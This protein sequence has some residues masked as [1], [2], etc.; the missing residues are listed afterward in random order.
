MRLRR[1]LLYYNGIFGLVVLFAFGCVDSSWAQEQGYQYKYQGKRD[2]FMSLI[3]P[4]GFLVNLEPEENSAIRLEG[5]MFDEAGESMAIVNG[6]LVRMGDEIG[7]SV[8][9]SIEPDRVTVIKD[10]QEVEMEL[11]RED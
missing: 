5:I 10:N 9:V 7:G 2:P 6:E 11:R 1:K 4:A 8:I 3:T